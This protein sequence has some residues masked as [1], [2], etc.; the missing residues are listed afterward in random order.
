MKLDTKNR[1]IYITFIYWGDRWDEWISIKDKNRIAPL[2]THTYTDED[3]TEIA[4]KRLAVGQRI[5]GKDT[6]NKW[7]E[8]FVKEANVDE[9][10]IFI[11]D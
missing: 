8:A 9:V 7:L 5:E 4:G 3:G 11:Y 10:Y 6:F 1:R 2:H